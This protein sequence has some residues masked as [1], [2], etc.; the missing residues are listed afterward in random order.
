MLACS[1]QPPAASPP[2]PPPPAPP[3]AAEPALQDREWGVLRSPAHGIKLAAPE[4]RAWVSPSLGP[5]GSS[6]ELR[7]EPTGSSLSLR[8]WR[9]SR[10]LQVDDCERELRARVPNLAERD[11]TSLVAERS[12]RAPAGFTTRIALFSLPGREK[13]LQG[14]VLAVGAGVGECIAA[15]AHTECSTEAELAERLRLFDTVFA[16]LRLIRVE[17]RV[18]AP[19]PLPPG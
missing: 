19:E 13:R 16:R 17:D 1:G 3:A 2:A 15:V 10:L 18:P 6:W 5:S 4:A 7:H 8:R 9:A 14:Q 11:E 12:V